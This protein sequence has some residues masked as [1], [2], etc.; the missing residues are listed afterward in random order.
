M[1]NLTRPAFLGAT[2]AALS[3]PAIAADGPLTTLRIGTS[4]DHDVVPILLGAQHGIFRKYGLDPIVQRMN[5]G[6]AVIPGVIGGSLE[7]GK[8]STFGLVLAQAKGF[9][10]MLE[11]VSS[12]YKR[13]CSE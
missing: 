3:A 10:I 13:R 4:P 5:S 9:P 7:V 1:P 2:F 11:A 12:Y 8:S 6:S